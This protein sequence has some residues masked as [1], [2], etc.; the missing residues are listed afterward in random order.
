MSNKLWRVILPAVILLVG[1]GIALGLILMRPGEAY[2]PR[3][4]PV[5]VVDLVKV[6]PQMGTVNIEADG[7]V[8]PYR[9]FQ[10]AAQVEGKVVFKAEL[11][12]AGLYVPPKTLLF[13]I[14]PTDYQLQEKRLEQEIRQAAN[15][16]EELQVEIANIQD[17]LRVAQQDYELERRSF[18]RQEELHRNRIISDA[19]YEQASRALLKAENALVTLQNQL[20]TAHSRK[21]SLEAALERVRT[22][23]AEVRVRLA[24]TEIYSPEDVETV[25]IRDDVELG[26]YVRVGTVLAVLEDL[27]RVEVRV[28]LRRDQFSWIWAAAARHSSE[29]SGGDP[30]EAY[31]L[32]PLPVTVIHELEGAKFTWEGFLWRY[33]GLGLNEAVRTV[34]CR[35]LVEDR[36][37]P[38][39]R[40]MPDSWRV[41]AGPPTLMRGMFV[42]VEIHLPPV[43]PM[44]C[45]PEEALQPGN[46][47]WRFDRQ[48]EAGDAK[49]SEGPPQG[50]E[51][52][53][54]TPGGGLAQSEAQGPQ[55]I[56]TPNS[57]QEALTA[58]K[59]RTGPVGRVRRVEVQPVTTRRVPRLFYAE[60]GL[61][62]LIDGRTL[63]FENGRL[64]EVISE[65]ETPK[66]LCPFPVLLQTREGLVP[67][68]GLRYQVIE[69]MVHE[70]TPEGT[71]ALSEAV[72]HVPPEA[73]L[74]I[75]LLRE[76]IVPARPGYLEAGDLIVVTPLVATDGTVVQARPEP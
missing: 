54:S 63:R 10:L 69:G 7:V 68:D 28:N 6:R 50:T 23:L 51:D 66:V 52:D 21:A 65:G 11:C 8:V 30:A 35:I 31:R 70:I 56:V 47:V 12:R 43:V 75:Q 41:P 59:G 44:L 60:D 13:R 58:D 74:G 53:Q 15:A 55:N 32:P 20:R 40:I 64:V 17:L 25:V 24:R 42:S 1:F 33:E 67:I 9:E 3:V 49:H 39:P 36:R 38:Q 57:A 72:I 29:R 2:V 5:P 22:Q 34:P 46:W 14:D 26:D 48:E 37:K 18:A 27:S 45:I 62:R 4:A 76:L 71:V 19:D 16:L 73:P 61:E